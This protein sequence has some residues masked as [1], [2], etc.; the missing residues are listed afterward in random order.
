MKPVIKYLII[1]IVV[2]FI[3]GYINQF[4]AENQ[5][6]HE[7]NVKPLFDRG[8]NLL[9]Q[10]SKNLANIG[11]I[12]FIVYFVVRWG[13]KYPYTIVNY[14]WIVSIL[15]VGRVIIFTMTQTPPAL[16]DCSTINTGDSLYFNVFR[17]NSNECLDYM[18]SGHS[19]HCVLI[20]L[21]TLYLP[22]SI[23]EKLFILFFL[24]LELVFIIGSRIHYTS[25]VLVATLVTVLIFL[26]W[27][28][29]TQ[30]I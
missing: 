27:Y 2:Y 23:W 28:R 19:I 18:Y 6:N 7:I 22:C 5:V 3:I 12:S 29:K 24:L 8:H 4:V 21:F 20:M 26:A 15:F 14:L 17:K 13:I 30:I 16:P 9:P 25:D 10:F 1:A 11:L